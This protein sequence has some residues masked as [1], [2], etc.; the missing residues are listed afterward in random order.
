M[1]TKVF[2]TLNFK[3]AN[4]TCD[5]VF[6]LYT[7]KTPLTADNFLKLCTGELGQ[8]FK[9]GKQAPA[10]LHYKGSGFHRIITDFMAQ[11]GDFTNHNGTGGLSIYGNKFA[12][13]NFLVKHDKP[14]L[15]SMANA[16]PNTNGSQFFLTFEKTPWLDGKHTVF[17]ELVEG[18]DIV[19][20]LKK[21]ST[22]NGKPTDVVTI[23]NCGRRD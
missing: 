15:L 12:D 19:N 2:M 4:I 16:G 10:N 21:V 3:N 9:T 22:S 1:T 14:Y 5:L 13:E 20:Q 8:V 6:K 17:G 7:D 23:V 11:G 18:V